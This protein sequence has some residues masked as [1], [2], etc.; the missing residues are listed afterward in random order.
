MHD[1][2]SAALAKHQHDTTRLV[3]IL[4]DLTEANGIITPKDITAIAEALSLPRGRVE[5]VAGFYAFFPTEPRGR[6][7]VLFSDNVTDEM[8][9]SVELRQRL[10]DAFHVELG[11]GVCLRR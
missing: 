1:D 5:G 11:E 4:R 10:L 3:Q 8:S 6:F 7:R 2:L 9:G